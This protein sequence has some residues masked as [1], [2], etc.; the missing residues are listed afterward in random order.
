MHC[1]RITRR[2]NHTCSEC[3]SEASD[4]R[5]TFY[6]GSLRILAAGKGGGAVACTLAVS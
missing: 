6:A 1:R 3:E 2:S 4:G 5:A